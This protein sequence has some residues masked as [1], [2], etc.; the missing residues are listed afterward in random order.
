MTA[1][2]ATAVTA[3]PVTAPV[4][5]A[6]AP[7][8]PVTT[9]TFMSATPLPQAPVATPV[10]QVT[11]QD[12]KI[13]SFLESF[14]A[15]LG[16][17]MFGEESYGDGEE[18]TRAAAAAGLPPGTELEPVAKGAMGD[19]VDNSL[20]MSADLED[21]AAEAAL[22]FAPGGEAG[23]D[24]MEDPASSVRSFQCDI[25]MTKLPADKHAYVQHM[26]MHASSVTLKCNFCPQV[27]QGKSLKSTSRQFCLNVFPL[28]P[29]LFYFLR[30]AGWQLV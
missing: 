17:D 6:V 11:S 10:Q 23:A 9:V 1:A 24:L 15:S 4:F 22:A 29:P 18:D 21:A 14:S 20:R 16:E 30:E 8:P 25:C 28:R 5:T 19:F 13:N 3:A 12:N 7:P 27:F 26:K 2:T